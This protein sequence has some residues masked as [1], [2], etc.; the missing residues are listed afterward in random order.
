MSAAKAATS[1]T[2]HLY[3][4]LAERIASLIREGALRPGDKVPSVRECSEQQQVS[5]ATV[6][7]AYRLLESRGLIEARPQ[8]GYYVKAKCWCPPAEPSISKPSPRATDVSVGELVVKVLQA[9][10]D[11]EL[12]GLGTALPGHELMPSEQLHRSLTA[13]GR[14]SPRSATGYDVPPGCPA[15]R[16][17]IARR[18]LAL[19]YSL[20]PDDIVT[21]CGAMEALNLCL[22][23]VAQPGD[24]IAIESPTYFGILQ[25]IESLGMKAL[26]IPTHPRDGVS[27]D[28]LEY[29][30]E[31]HPIKACLFVLNYNNPL[32]SCMPTENKRRLVKMLAEREIPLIEDD[33]YGDLAFESP[34]PTV[35]KSFDEKGLVL[36]C[37]SFSKTLAPGYRVG[38]VAPGRFKDRVILLK[39][40]S[41]LATGSLAQLT[42]ADFLANGNYDHHLRKVRRVYA[43]Q[44]QLFTEAIVQQFPA[45]TRVTRP[46][47][48]HVLWVELPPQY[49][50]LE[51]FERALAAK[52]S[53][54]PGPM[55]SAKG[56]FRNFIR[57]NCGH[58]WSDRIAQ[59]LGTLGH[60]LKTMD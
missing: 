13:I 3:E 60:I 20:A 45:G 8:S 22:R 19:G 53:I 40:V 16:A 18:S 2:Q 7:Q 1:E 28:A 9:T 14:R 38:W 43:Q 6:L 42:I 58:V 34:R 46:E 15:L 41:T 11:P 30:L 36:L 50:S 5:I 21:T 55:F 47:G 10:R 49:D 27:L 29:A 39:C 26:E 4:K 44:V 17:Q 35:A 57:L 31:Q 32:G 12:I 37:D 51:L 48:G 24:T 59:S 25:L 33:I 52:I 56:K 23:A 54:A